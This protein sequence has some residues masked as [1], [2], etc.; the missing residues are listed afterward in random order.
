M[1]EYLLLLFIDPGIKSPSGVSSI[2]TAPESRS[3]PEKVE[4]VTL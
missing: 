2:P 3:G 4:R 1:P